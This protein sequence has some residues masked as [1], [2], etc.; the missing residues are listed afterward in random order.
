[1][2]KHI[3]ENTLAQVEATR[4]REIDAVRQKV[5]QEEIIPFNCDIDNSLREAIAELQTQHNAKIMQLQQA[6]EAEKSALAEAANRRKECNA[7]VAIANAIRAIN[8]K[9]DK[10]IAVI[11]KMISEEA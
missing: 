11:N 6:F 7:E 5:M 10:E 4:Q 2:Y 9:A 1:M 3:Y 8:E